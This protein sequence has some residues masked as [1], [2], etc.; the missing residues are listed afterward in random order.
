VDGSTAG[1]YGASDGAFARSWVVTDQDLNT[2]MP[3]DDYKLVAVT[4]S[5]Y[6]GKAARSRTVV[7]TGGKSSQ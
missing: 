4:V 5:W 6:D 3:G 2:T 1:A 7:V